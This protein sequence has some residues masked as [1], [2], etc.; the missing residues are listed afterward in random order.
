MN[1][2][3]VLMLVQCSMAGPLDL[4]TL[5]LVGVRKAFVDIDSRY[6]WS[7]VWLGGS[8]EIG[9]DVGGGVSVLICGAHWNDFRRPFSEGQKL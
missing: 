1:G 3:V 7:T 4:D 9:A 2:P 8:E 6:W 5:G